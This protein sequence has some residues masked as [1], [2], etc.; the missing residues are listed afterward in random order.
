MAQKV[1]G[2]FPVFLGEDVTTVARELL[3]CYLV[4]NIGEHSIRAKIVETESY[5]Q[6]DAASH[7]FNGRTARTDVMFGESGHL[8]VYF[9]YGLHYCCNV[10]TGAVGEGSAV[11]IR[12]VE[13]VEGR[14]FVEHH[15]GRT[16]ID[17]TNGPAKLCQALDIDK[18]LNGHNLRYFPLRLETG[19]PL[20]AKAIMTAPRIGISKE[21][22]ALRRFYIRG[23][24]YVS[25]A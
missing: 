19:L 24:A 16:G 8:Y 20:P 4:R 15:R 22:E 7:S 23:N 11:L 18:R 17:A 6:A 9:T 2:A 12:A 3:G 10:V 21:R 5:D 14:D 25:N 1:A 13:P